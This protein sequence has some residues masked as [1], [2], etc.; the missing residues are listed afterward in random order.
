[1]E[2]SGHWRELWEGGTQAQE[3]FRSPMYEPEY[4]RCLSLKGARVRARDRCGARKRSH[5]VKS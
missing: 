5:Q 3:H 4:R 2:R 1:M